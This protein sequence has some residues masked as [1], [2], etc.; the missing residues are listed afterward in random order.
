MSMRFSDLVV[1]IV[2]KE[3]A[4]YEMKLDCLDVW[5]LIYSYFGS[6]VQ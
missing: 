2:A 3:W 4:P 6:K 5:G 1:R